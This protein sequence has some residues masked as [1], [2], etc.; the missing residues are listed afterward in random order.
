MKSIINFFKEILIGIWVIIAIFTTVCLLS[1]NEYGIS[2][3]G[4]TSLFIVDNRSL[5]EFGFNKHDIIIVTKGLEK[6]Y[7]EGSGVFYSAGN[8]ETKSFI[9]YSIIER[10]ER[11]D[12]AE[13]SFYFAD[14]KVSY[15]DILGL[16]NGALRIKKLGLLLGLLESRW[17]FM[18][19][20]ILPTL[21]AF[22]Y[23]VY[24]IAVEV[25]KKSAKE[26][27]EAEENDD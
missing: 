4:D 17:G 2:E 15:G 25:K 3:F 19:L 27:A 1:S 16:A 13:D 24:T 6:E 9:N 11:A 5:E 22:V 26:L 7:T 18:F 23:E 12:G 21:Y 8:I 20:I 14:D 10:A